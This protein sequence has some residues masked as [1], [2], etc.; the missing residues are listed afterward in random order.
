MFINYISKKTDLCLCLCYKDLKKHLRNYSEYVCRQVKYNQ[1]RIRN[2]T[3]ISLEIILNVFKFL[4]VSLTPLEFLLWQ[5]GQF[6]L[7]QLAFSVN[8]L[9]CQECTFSSSLKK[10][11]YTILPEGTDIY[12]Q[13]HIHQ[14]DLNLCLTL[15]YYYTKVIVEKHRQGIQMCYCDQ[16]VL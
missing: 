3:G 4:I 16:V 13:Q 15:L 5:Y 11:R 8:L 14:N 2:E 9:W 1:H 7:F 6:C 10:K 12:I